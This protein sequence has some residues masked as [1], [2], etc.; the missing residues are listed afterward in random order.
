MKKIIRLTESDLTRIVRRVIMEQGTINNGQPDNRTDEEIR[1]LANLIDSIV[2]KFV[3]I[4]PDKT[5]SEQLK[6]RSL[7]SVK[8]EYANALDMFFKRNGFTNGYLDSTP[9]DYVSY[10][11]QYDLLNKN[12]K[13]WKSNY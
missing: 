1:N 6:K 9:S 13:N 12:P 11:T 8:A 10:K 3:E 7:N 5:E 4:Y 2:K